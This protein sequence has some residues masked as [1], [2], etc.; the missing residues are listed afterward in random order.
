MRAALY[1]SIC[2]QTTLR[3]KTTKAAGK[4][5]LLT[6]LLMAFALMLPVSA[7]AQGGFVYVNNQKSSNSVSIYKVFPT[8]SIT[9]VGSPVLTGGVGANVVCYGLDRIVLSPVN[10]LLFVANTGDRTIT[11]FTINPSTGALTRTAGSP[12]ASGLTADA[13]QGMSLAVTPD[14]QFLM[15]SSNGQIRTFSIAAGGALTFV[16]STANCCT[17]NAGMV[18]SPDGR[19]LA[20]SN[21]SSVSMFTI[22]AGVLTPVLG[23]PFPKLGPGNLSGLD[24]SCKADRLY[25]GEA[26]GSPAIAEGWTVDTTGI[27]TPAPQSP[28]QSSGTNSNIV[29]FSP[30]NSLLFQSNQFTNSINSFMV[31]GDGSITNAGKF[32]GTTAVH[33]PVGMAT[34]ASGNFLYVADDTYG[35]AVFRIGNGGLLASLKDL[36]ITSPGEIQDLVAYP[37]RSCGSADLGLLMTAVPSPAVAGAPI[38]YSLNITNNGP[39]TASAVVA[40][41]LPPTLS[42]GGTALIANPSGAQRTN[43]VSG[44]SVSGAVTITT[45]VPHQ[46]FLGESVTVSSVPAPTTPNPI[47]SGFFLNDPTFNGVFTV[48]SIPSSTSFTYSQTIPV[49][50]F[51]RPTLQIVA[52]TGAQRL[53]NVVTITTTQVFQ[54]APGTLVDISGVANTSFN[55]TGVTVLSQPTATTFTYA[56]TGPDAISGGGTVTGPRVIPPT[57]AAGG[58]SANSPPCVV[59]LGPAT[60]GSATFA[61]HPPILSAARTG[62]VVT[63]TTPLPHQLFAG[64]IVTIQ[65]VAN[66]TFNGTFTIVSV[67][68]PTTFTYN[69][70]AADATS[71]GGAVVGPGIVSQLITFNNMTSGETRT[72][73]I[74]ATSS[75][76]LA[77]GTVI[78][79][80]ANISNLSVVDP[81]P[82]LNSSTAPVTIGTTGATTLTVP[83]A[84]GPYGGVATV[85]AT[86]KDSAG[87]PIAGETVGF[88]FNQDNSFYNA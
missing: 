45:T 69:Q 33:V 24:F 13:C 44:T 75:G 30:D 37:Q 29:R 64:N 7:L 32:G 73:V 70:T 52:S 22:T 18:I 36:A 1:N 65:G 57:D 3:A 17:P 41:A 58:G 9:Q 82:A 72:A 62:N 50:S 40:D 86:L 2:A 27:L 49:T 78:N 10:N 20:V 55:A 15:A 23:S 59:T 51:P 16:S 46:L 87:N 81:G 4:L 76:S 19:F 38:L 83:T 74:N 68:S 77:N 63:I 88:N 31:N 79:N 43:T 67:P 8:G 21:Q 47:Q 61:P 60:C 71:S 35:L 5:W 85:T 12:F 34:D 66:T 25:A 6:A 14:G 48:A 54:L 39:D 84:T 28:F 56:Q 42:A 53:S 26:T 11:P 80:T